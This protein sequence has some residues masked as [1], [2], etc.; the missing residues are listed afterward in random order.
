M[1]CNRN[2]VIPLNAN[3]H[4][5]QTLLGKLLLPLPLLLSLLS[6]PLDCRNSLLLLLHPPLFRLGFLF[7]PLQLLS[8]CLVFLLLCKLCQFSSQFLGSASRFIG[9]PRRL[10]SV[11][12]DLLQFSLDSLSILLCCLLG[13]LKLRPDLVR[14]AGVPSGRSVRS[15]RRLWG[16]ARFRRRRGW[17]SLCLPLLPVPP[18]PSTAA[19]CSL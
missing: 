13:G 5:P 9:L 14:D 16:C 6:R 3:T 11:S 4:L 2:P 19:T 17:L 10:A 7:L 12:S 18:A 1:P 15:V 8:A